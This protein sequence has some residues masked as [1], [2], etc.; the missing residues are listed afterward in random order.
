MKQFFVGL[1]LLTAGVWA[2]PSLEEIQN[3]QIGD[4]KKIHEWMN[5]K[6]T[7]PRFKVLILE[8]RCAN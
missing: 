3:I 8:S 7:K 1:L 4:I 2:E 6:K 5:D